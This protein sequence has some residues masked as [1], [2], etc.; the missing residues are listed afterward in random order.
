[1]YVVQE[2]APAMAATSDQG[3]AQLMLDLSAARHV[4]LSKSSV[5]LLLKSGRLVLAHLTI[6]AGMVKHMRVSQLP[7]HHACHAKTSA[8]VHQ[9]VSLDPKNKLASSFSMNIKVPSLPARL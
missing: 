8:R 6:E 7:V 5:A 9:C 4:W 1:M 3:A 2:S